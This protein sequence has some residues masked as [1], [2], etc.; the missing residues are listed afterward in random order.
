MLIPA[1]DPSFQQKGYPANTEELNRLVRRCDLLEADL[2]EVQTS[3]NE[4]GTL[5]SRYAEQLDEETVNRGVLELALDQSKEA[6]K[7]KIGELEEA[8]KEIGEKNQVIE[9]QNFLLKHAWEHNQTL[10]TTYREREQKMLLSLAR[11]QDM[12]ECTLPEIGEGHIDKKRK[13]G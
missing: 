8:S 7:I 6:L 1:S 11:L 2:V 5:A 3:R 12:S 4:L 13:F 10:V 9:T